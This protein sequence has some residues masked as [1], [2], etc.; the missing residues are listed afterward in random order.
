M[1][2][3]VRRRLRRVLT[4]M[5]AATITDTGRH[6]KYCRLRRRLK[7]TCHLCRLFVSDPSRYHG[8]NK[9]KGGV[10]YGETLC[11]GDVVTITLD[12]NN[13]TLSYARNGI[14]LGTIDHHHHQHH[15][16]RHHPSSSSSSSS[17]FAAS[18][19]LS[20]GASIS[21][22]GGR[23]RFLA[24]RWSRTDGVHYELDVSFDATSVFRCLAG[25]TVYSRVGRG[26]VLG[27]QHDSLLVLVDGQSEPT[28]LQRQELN[29][30]SKQV[31][32]VSDRHHTEVHR[33]FLSL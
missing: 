21:F 33:L 19:R 20:S 2:S 18:E 23:V 6:L 30:D 32:F 9:V 8:R 5:L 26:R 28:L 17:T 22:A 14:D 7:L 25:Q 4:S 12:F 10:K 29:N 15:H 3:S 11:V 31:R 27:V 24:A 16:R 1:F 13:R